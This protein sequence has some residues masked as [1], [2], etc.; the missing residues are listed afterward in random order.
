MLRKKGTNDRLFIGLFIILT[1]YIFLNKIKKSRYFITIVNKAREMN[2]WC[3]LNIL[4]HRE[5]MGGTHT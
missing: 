2:A 1:I 5:L 4:V 3:G